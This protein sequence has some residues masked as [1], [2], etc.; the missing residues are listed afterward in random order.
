M[1]GRAWPKGP[2]S[3]PYLSGKNLMTLCGRRRGFQSA[4]SEGLSGRRLLAGHG[5]PLEY[6]PHKAMR[7]F[8]MAEARKYHFTYPPGSLG[9]IDNAISTAKGD[10]GEE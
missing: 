2:H 8:D 1:L 6:V 3:H 10:E 5:S 7:A 9:D 4:P